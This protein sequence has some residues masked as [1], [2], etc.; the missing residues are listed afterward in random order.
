MVFEEVA[1]GSKAGGS[2]IQAGP[3]SCSI[4][5]VAVEREGKNPYWGD[6]RG[7]RAWEGGLALLQEGAR[8]GKTSPIADCCHQPM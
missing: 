1:A 6:P 4:G 8:G 3:A 7:Q 5:E 2:S